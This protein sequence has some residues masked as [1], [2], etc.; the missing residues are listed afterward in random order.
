MQHRTQ[1]ADDV[2]GRIAEQFTR[3]FRRLRAGTIKDLAPLGLTFS[4]ARVLRI[5]GRAEQPPR[6][7]DL[8][9]K[10]EIAP[11]S[12]TGIVDALENAGLTARTAD[13]VDRRS[14]RVGLTPKGR[15]LLGEMKRTRRANAEKLFGQLEGAQQLQLLEILDTLNAAERPA[16][17]DEAL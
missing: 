17:K 6:I 4:Q 16:P 2:V 5:I 13:S 14:V 7:G 9:A 12:A 8:A 15:E 3:A 10:L 11:R 1:E